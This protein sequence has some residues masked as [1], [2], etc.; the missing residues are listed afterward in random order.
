MR[1]FFAPDPRVEV[2]G[3]LLAAFYASPHSEKITPILAA[4]GYA[5]INPNA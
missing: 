3:R 1:K 5:T 4:A 2:H